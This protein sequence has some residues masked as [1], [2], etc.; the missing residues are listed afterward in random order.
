MPFHARRVTSGL[1]RSQP[2]LL[3]LFLVLALV[4]PS[5]AQ[6]APTPNNYPPP[7][8]YLPQEAY[9]QLG[10]VPEASPP[11]EPAPEAPVVAALP[12]P[13]APKTPPPFTF[14][15]TLATTAIGETNS[16]SVVLSPLLEG[17]YAIYPALLLDLVWGASW[18]VDGQGLGE[19]T[20]RVGNPMVSGFYRRHFDAWQ[21]R[22]GL[23]VTAPLAHYALDPNGRVYAFTYNQTMAMWGM[24][25][26]WLWTT[27]RMAVPA[28]FRVGYT[29]PG[30]QVL[31]VEGAIGATF[32]VRGSTDNDYFI[33]IRFR[34][35]G[36]TI[37]VGNDL[38][39]QIALETQ[40][41]IGARFVLC[42]R[43]QTALLPASSLDR[44][45][46][47]FGLRGILNTTRGK[48]F[49]GLLVNLDEPLGVFSGLGRWGL[50]L[51]KEIDL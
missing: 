11:G 33:R 37:S 7:D 27:D 43:L 15:A 32:A 4:R 6:P 44:W 36:N 40:I 3:A 51:G 42:P 29:L 14:G 49:A 12:P 45:Q 8:Y 22:V 50:H 9:P 18:T 26:Q 31:A 21:V 35:S 1:A 34:E 17:A 30:G 41:P 23:G 16:N 38:L 5:F 10:P 47:A 39:S 46:S 19:S 25:N 24:W 28:M 20:A 48:Y 2:G 13:S